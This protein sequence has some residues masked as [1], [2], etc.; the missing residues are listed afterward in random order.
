[1][2]T[3][4]KIIAA[5]SLASAFAS[6]SESPRGWSIEGTVNLPDSALMLV[7]AGNNGRWY[8]VDTVH[9]HDGSFKYQASAPAPYPDV[10]R[11]AFEGNYIYFPVDS[12][13]AIHVLSDGGMN[14][15]LTGTLSASTISA[16]DSLIRVQTAK[17]GALNVISDDNFKKELFARA[18]ADPSVLPGYYLLNRTVGPH[19]LFDPSRKADLR[20]FGAVAQ[21][22]TTDRPDDIRGKFISHQFLQGRA[23]AAGVQPSR[24]I[25]V[26]ETGVLEINRIDREGVARSLQEAAAKGGVLL[27]SFTN[28]SAESSPAYNVVLG[29]IYE[30]N[31]DKGLEI[32][33]IAFDSDE[34]WW[35]QTADKLP[36]I[37]V[38]NSTTDDFQP[39][40]SYN[41]GVLPTTFII[42]RNGTIRER[43]V[44]PA[45]LPAAVKKYI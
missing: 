32:Y 17:D 24:Q 20:M 29:D 33:Q 36:W 27:L 37:T 21:R 22:F 7:E 28:Y 31:H 6:C 19:R 5:A 45:D 10:M 8:T 42:D 11:L 3:F 38:W 40:T 18:F 26:P 2:N 16:L 15:S 43:V 25:T 34:T 12:I 9:I 41:V 14:Y 35:R 23:L 4:L 44:D 1:M 13:D 30:A 39:L